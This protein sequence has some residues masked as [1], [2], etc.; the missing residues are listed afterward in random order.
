M[1]DDADH[2]G[3]ARPIK[4]SVYF[5]EVVVAKRPYLNQSLIAKVI[6]S[7]EVR[8]VQADGRIRLCGRREELQ[9]RALRVVLLADGETVHNAFID[10]DAPIPDTEADQSHETAI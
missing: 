10:R 7:P 3:R 8:Q 6:D 2:A 5:R 9:G 4:T 1:A